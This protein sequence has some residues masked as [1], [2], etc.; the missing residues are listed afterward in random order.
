MV[1]KGHQEYYFVLPTRLRERIYSIV[2]MTSFESP[3]IAL[4]PYHPDLFLHILNPAEN[5]KEN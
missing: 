4:E 3:K 5:V 2:V 1:H